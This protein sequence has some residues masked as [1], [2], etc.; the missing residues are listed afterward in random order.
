MIWGVCYVRLN[1]FNGWFF[2]C[3]INIWWLKGEFFNFKILKFV[4][5]C[6]KILVGNL[7]GNNVCI[8]FLILFLFKGKKEK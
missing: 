8:L 2:S 3:V 7:V 1:V 5:V 4:L 6:G